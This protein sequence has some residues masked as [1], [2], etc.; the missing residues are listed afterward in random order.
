[1]TPY[2]DRD[3]ITIYHGDCREVLPTIDPATVALVIADPPYGIALDTANRSRKR[4]ALAAANDY[5]S[6]V[7]DDEPFDP[8]HLFRFRRLML[9][10]ANHYAERLPASASWLVWNKTAGLRSDRPIGF[11]DNADAELIW[12]NLGGPVRILGHQWIGLMKATERGESRVHP[13]Q[14]P[15]ALV[16]WLIE[17]YTKPGDLILDPYMGSGTT[18]RACADSGRRCI[19][20]DVVREYCRVAVR[21]LA[22]QVLPFVTEEAAD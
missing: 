4:G 20:V 22:Q 16:R 7:A 21:R 12:T 10:G 5:A 3:G 13:T 1:M 14:K 2:Y 6:V 8:S 18:P 19:A 15:V 11:N 17:H 9:F